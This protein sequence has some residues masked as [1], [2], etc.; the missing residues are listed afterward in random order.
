VL[1]ALPRL[2]L[3]VTTGMGNAAVDV[4]Y[5]T[6]RRVTVCGTGRPGGPPAP[7]L[8]GTAEV[9]WALVLAVTKRVTIEDRAIRDGHW[10]LGV[11][12][13]LAGATLGLAGLGHLG[14]ARVAPARAFGMEV[15]AWSQN[16]T[17]ERAGSLGV[18]RVTK[19]ELLSGSDVVSVHLVLSDRS[20]GLFQAAD[21]ALMK[22]TA[23]LVNT[24]RGPIVDEQALIAALRSKTIAGAGL[25]VYDT[26]PLPAGHALT[27]LDD[28][29]LLPHLGYASEP[30][31]R[32]MYVQ[33]VAD[34]AAFLGGSP[35]RTI[36]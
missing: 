6:E 16:L 15:V 10:Q 31:F 3:L 11:P 30:G 36:S 24:S 4:G 26:E 33:A 35:I 23:V 7:G 22:P 20:R 5:L 19:S 8:P 17:D 2:A 9:A 27:G 18:R 13:V 14:A 32:N 34:I 21:L 25:D 12:G 1:E 29:V 28:V